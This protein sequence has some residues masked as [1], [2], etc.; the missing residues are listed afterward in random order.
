MRAVYRV[1][2]WLVAVEV[3]VQAAAIT[4]AVF[5]LGQWI[6]GGG[7]LDKSVM[8]SEVQ[9]FPA[10]TGFMVHGLNGQMV[11]PV[12]ALLL[13]VVSFFAT[14]PR[15]VA[16]AGGV[17]GLVAVQVALGMLGHGL[18]WLGLLH[19]ANALALVAVAV[20]A[21]RR[22]GARAVVA[23]PRTAGRHTAGTPI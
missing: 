23:S 13:L 14:V 5:G 7:V 17:V 6:Q 4:W 8:E 2:A 9:A 1:L 3:L 15:G 19:G 12:L 22:A 18:P 10:E 20:V 16:L 21:A 11:V